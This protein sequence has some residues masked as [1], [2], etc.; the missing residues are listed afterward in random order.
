M[1]RLFFIFVMTLMA[2]C[3]T[4]EDHLM[5]NGVEI[6]GQLSL[7]VEALQ[8]QNWTVTKQNTNEAVLSGIFN[9]QD[10]KLYAFGSEKSHT[11][12]KVVVMLGKAED[13]WSTIWTD[14]NSYKE[15]LKKEYGEPF[16]SIEENR[17]SITQDNPMFSV[18]MG[19]VEY[20]TLFK[21]DHGNIKLSIEKL[22]YPLDVHNCITYKE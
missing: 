13:E 5:F 20:W 21:A 18:R 16:R 22:M 7:F 10:A 11:V 3:M 1:K 19:Q 6:D 2:V 17:D 9:G 14:Y 8:Q 4:A 12:F 15:L